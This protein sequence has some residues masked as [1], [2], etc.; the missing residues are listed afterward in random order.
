MIKIR[1]NFKGSGGKPQ[2]TK[3]GEKQRNFFYLRK[4]RKLKNQ[5]VKIRSSC[6]NEVIL[7]KFCKLKNQ[8]VKMRSSCEKISQVEEPISQRRTKLRN[9]QSK[10]SQDQSPSCGNFRSCETPS[11]HMCAIS[12][13]QNPISQLRNGHQVAKWPL[14]CENV[15][16]HLNTYLNL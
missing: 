5:V 13:P 14:G 11:R 16:H 1:R 4:F 7:R 3:E 2:R 8:V 15:N 10:I 12:H 6:E 9:P